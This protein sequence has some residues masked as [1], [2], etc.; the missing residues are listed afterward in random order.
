M[1]KLFLAVA[2]CCCMWQ[3]TYIVGGSNDPQLQWVAT[4]KGKGDAV[5]A[6][7]EPEVADA[8]P[9][10]LGVD[11]LMD[12]DCFVKSFY[13]MT[14]WMEGVP[15]N[16][17]N[18]YVVWVP[19]ARAE[20]PLLPTAGFCTRRRKSRAFIVRYQYD[21]CLPNH[22]FYE[23]TLA[24]LGL[25]CS[26]QAVQQ[27]RN[28]LVMLWQQ[29]EAGLASV[30]RAEGLTSRGYTEALKKNLWGGLPE[31]QLLSGKCGLGYRIINEKKEVIAY[32]PG[33]FLITLLKVH[34]HFVLVK[35]EGSKQ[36]HGQHF[37]AVGRAGM[38]LRLV[39]NRQDIV[40]EVPT[41]QSGSEDEPQRHAPP[42][43][44]MRS[45]SPRRRSR[46]DRKRATRCKAST[47]RHEHQEIAERQ[48]H[49]EQRH[50]ELH[51]DER[52]RSQHCS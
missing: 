48:V 38:P 28:F 30:A 11:A 12:A 32:V 33:T 34:D 17:V 1:A 25:E 15:L 44:S 47:G 9:Q 10:T 37:A 41:D 50:T 36:R 7:V 14:A 45:R 24:A 13:T 31:M 19:Q 49:D 8:G 43:P 29:D 21:P 23:A 16:F 18:P 3:S 35:A 42:P 52:R 40:I 22:C 26:L 51:E 20:L 4:R 39:G 46:K 27:L 2:A 5:Q 6:Q